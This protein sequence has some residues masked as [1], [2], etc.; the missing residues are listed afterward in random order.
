MS[1]L[2][3]LAFIPLVRASLGTPPPSGR[4]SSRRGAVRPPMI[5]IA[6]EPAPVVDLS[7]RKADRLGKVYVLE[8]HHIKVG[9]GPMFRSAALFQ[10]DLERLYRLGFRPVT[11][12]EYVENRMDLPKGASPVVLTFDDSHPDQVRLR[13]D[14]SLDRKSA[15]GLLVA[16]S[17]RHPDFPPKATFYAQSRFFG[18]KAERAAKVKLLTSLGCEIG[19]HTMNHPDLGRVSSERVKKEIAGV[20]DLLTKLGLTGPFSLAIPYGVMPRD[21]SLVRS[22][23]YRGKTYRIRNNAYAFYGAARSPEDPKFFKYGINRIVA[24]PGDEG[25]DDYLARAARGRI[26][27]YVAAGPTTVGRR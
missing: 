6:S 11:M 10:S 26:R 14:G 22:F 5:R 24:V 19:N 21:R 20:D 25:V 13:K 15:L 12:A 17:E 7:R 9:K 8:Y 4:P 2:A 1:L 18:A 16:F 27:L 23:T 3:A